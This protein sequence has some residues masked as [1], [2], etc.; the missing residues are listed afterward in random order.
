VVLNHA[1]PVDDSVL[2]YPPEGTL[3]RIRSAINEDVKQIAEGDDPANAHS[4]KWHTDR[5]VAL[6]E[7]L[8]WWE[9][10]TLE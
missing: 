4:F 2:V 7:Y 5:K 6:D 9:S 3:M 10:T 1:Q 8:A